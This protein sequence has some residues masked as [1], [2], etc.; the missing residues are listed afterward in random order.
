MK[1]VVLDAVSIGYRYIDCA[2]R[3]KNQKEV[4]EALTQIFSEGKVKRE[5]LFITS[6]VGLNHLRPE[7]IAASIRNT[8]KDLQLTYVDLF[9]I[10]WP[11]ALVDGEIDIPFDEEGY[12][13]YDKVPLAVSWA[14]MEKVCEEGLAKSIGV[15]NFPVAVLN[16]LLTTAKIRPAMNQIESHPYFQERELIEY[17]YT[18]GIS[19]TAYAP[20]ARREDSII[21]GN[22]DLL[23][24][25]VIVGIAK[26]YNRGP[27]QI[28]LRWG[29][30]R[31][32]K[33][34]ITGEEHPYNHITII[35]K[36]TSKEHLA[37]NFNVFDFSLSNE[38][39]TQI[40]GLERNLRLANTVA[41]IHMP[42]FS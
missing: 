17:C 16:N 33:S 39:L 11:I 25:P 27:S 2:E 5:D 22:V 32:G 23:T 41:F 3:Y 21:R 15:S 10:H 37:E 13:K 4:G 1:Q 9:L 40:D 14:A 20:L 18:Q 7:A 35:P 29:L 8:L 19:I 6:K 24:D 34:Y 42:V 30:Q 12:P 26:K 36:A 38:D 31:R 28:V